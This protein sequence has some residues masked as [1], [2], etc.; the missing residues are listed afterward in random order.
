[1]AKQFDNVL[2]EM[3]ALQS[4]KKA[5]MPALDKHLYEIELVDKKIRLLEKEKAEKLN[6]FNEMLETNALSSHS[7]PNGFY[8][9]PDDRFKIEIDNVE[10]FLKWLKTNVKPLEVLA[11]FKTAIKKTELK[12]FCEH[13]YNMKRI[14]GVQDPKIDGIT[15]GEKTYRRLTTEYKKG[16]K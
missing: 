1:M 9:R 4:N 13:H 12:R 3:A 16:K 8:A 2:A 14:E 5:A 15:I 6:K 11:F 10:L 7:L